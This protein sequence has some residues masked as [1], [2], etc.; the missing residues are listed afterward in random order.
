[1]PPEVAMMTTHTIG[2][3]YRAVISVNSLLW[4]DILEDRVSTATTEKHWKMK[5][6]KEELQNKQDTGTHIT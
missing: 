6:G 2:M 3:K 4:L 5:I 1:M